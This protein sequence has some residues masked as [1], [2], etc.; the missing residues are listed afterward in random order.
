MAGRDSAF[1]RRA[2]FVPVFLA[3][4]L[5]FRDAEGLDRWEVTGKVGSLGERKL[6]GRCGEFTRGGSGP[7]VRMFHFVHWIALLDQLNPESPSPS[8][9]AREGEAATKP[10]CFALAFVGHARFFRAGS[11]S[12]CA[13]Q[14]DA[15]RGLTICG[16]L[17]RLRGAMLNCWFMHAAA[18]N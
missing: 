16:V 8:R 7:Q 17:V 10:K 15:L 14:I 6:Y 9:K 18:G 5:R 12:A 4:L 3:G 11:F 2:D 1:C 13:N